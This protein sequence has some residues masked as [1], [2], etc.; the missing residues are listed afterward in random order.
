M[1]LVDVLVRNDGGECGHYWM[2]M[3]MHVWQQIPHVI[4]GYP[5]IGLEYRTDPDM[6][7]PQWDDFDQRYVFVL[8]FM[9]LIANI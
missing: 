6:T 2:T 7:M 5:Y 3:V 1:Q 9:V 8:C 4:L